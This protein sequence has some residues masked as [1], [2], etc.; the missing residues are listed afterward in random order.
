VRVEFHPAAEREL[1]AAAMLGERRSAGLG[2][3]LVAES[4]RIAELLSKA[5]TIG[6]LID[7]RHRR[8]PLSR[9]PFALVYRV[10]TDR[11]LLIAFSHR[12]R[13]PGY[14]SHRR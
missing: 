4:R 8:F 14:W 13:K 2:V 1:A 11:L 12:R 7:A 5:P 9:F 3:A 10:E 6:E